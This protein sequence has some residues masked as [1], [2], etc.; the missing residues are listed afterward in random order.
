MRLHAW[1]LQR[2]PALETLP[3]EFPL[4]QSLLDDALA[5]CGTLIEEAP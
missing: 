5:F 3:W 1:A 2:S 4:A